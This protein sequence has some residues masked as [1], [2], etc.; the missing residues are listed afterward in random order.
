L[1]V[2]ERSTT[3]AGGD[4]KQPDKQETSSWYIMRSS[5][6]GH[7]IYRFGKR[8]MEGILGE[9]S[10]IVQKSE[11]MSEFFKICPFSLRVS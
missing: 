4:L 7:P 5:Y 3:T 9:S 8:I 2:V 10:L 1:G 11:P 6:P